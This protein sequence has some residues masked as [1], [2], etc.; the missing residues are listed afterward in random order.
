M[1]CP[2]SSRRVAPRSRPDGLYGFREMDP[3]PPQ[4]RV[5]GNWMDSVFTRVVCI[6]RPR[7][8]VACYAEWSGQAL[9]R[10]RFAQDNE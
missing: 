3:Y 6:K 7:S 2:Y 4:F 10:C 8:F 5:W 9:Y 1:M